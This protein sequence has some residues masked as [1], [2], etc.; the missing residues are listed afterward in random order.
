MNLLNLEIESL[1]AE[2]RGIAHLKTEEGQ[3]GKVVFV[4]DALPK[5][6]VSVRITRRK[7]Q[8]EEADLLNV[9]RESSLRVKPGCK[10]FGVCG[11]CIMQHLED[12]GQI[13][14]KQRVLEDNFAR[15]GQ[16]KPLNILQPIQALSW[17]YRHR[18][19]LSVR[20]VRKKA[21]VL[22]G[23]H[24]RKTHY[25]VETET[26]PILA[27]PLADLIM[28]L[29]L[30]IEQLSIKEQIPQIEVA[31]T[32]QNVA[33]V[34]RIMQTPSEAD[35]HKL[36]AFADQHQIQ[37]WLQTGSP[38][39]AYAWYPEHPQMLSYSLPELALQ[40][41]FKPTEFTQI[42]PLVNRKMVQR[43]LQLLRP[44][45][46]ERILDL[47]CGLGNF[48]LPL[49]LHAKQVV[50]IEGSQSLVERAKHNAQKNN[51]NNTQ[52]IAANL[53]EWT[54]DDLQALGNFDKI[55]ID[56]PRDGAKAMCE[57]IVAQ[58]CLP[59]AIVYVSCNPATLARD[60]GYLVNHGSY[61]LSSAGIINMFAHTGHVESIAVFHL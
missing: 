61:T 28:P 56:P 54:K 30:L 15:I 1:D 58:P 27:K 51:L 19:R 31:I 23:F 43:A 21:K 25:V 38:D 10:K 53:F 60:A 17:H 26:C 14:I 40:F 18:A 36:K 39:K 45:A 4:S 8:W 6:Q 32:E 2:A 49:A 34:L 11:G 50:G 47:F 7:A 24:E 3:R 13:A 29:R 55:L 52:F 59:K 35:E 37:W 33:L 41:E 12:N 42:N 5:E 44:E 22:I 9:L 46:H 57:A 20:Y 16:V 48:T